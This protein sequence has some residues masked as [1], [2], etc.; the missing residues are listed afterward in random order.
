MIDWHP[1]KE[2]LQLVLKKI[3]FDMKKSK[4]VIPTIQ[5]IGPKKYSSK[6]RNQLNGFRKN[7][8]NYKSVDWDVDRKKI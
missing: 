5:Q 1:D 6:R 3:S 7:F 4:T 2:L 8:N